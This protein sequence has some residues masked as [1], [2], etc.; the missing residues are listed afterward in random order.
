MEF[1][2]RLMAVRGAR[3]LTRPGLSV[4]AGLARDHVRLIEV[5]QV[6]EPTERTKT[7]LAEALCVA[8]SERNWFIFG[9]GSCP[10]WLER[11]AS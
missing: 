1:I 7:R 6:G 5:G 10:R 3:G 8:G 4:A 2:E 11:K 9:I